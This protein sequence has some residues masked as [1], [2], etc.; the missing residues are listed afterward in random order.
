MIFEELIDPLNSE[1]SVIAE[2][3]GNHQS[4]LKSAMQF[5]EEAIRY[6][7]DIIKFQVYKPDTI[8]LKSTFEDFRV[9][10]NSSWKE[11]RFLY[12]LYEKAYT[13][14]D[15]IETIASYLDSVQFPWFASP[16]DITAIEFLE[17]I[18][19]PAY[20][21]ASPEITD[22]GLIETLSTTGKPIILSTGLANK[23][24]LDLAVNTIKKRHCKF[25]ILKCTSAYPAPYSDLNLN[26][27]PKLIENYKCA[28]G[29]SDHT[30]GFDAAKTAVALGATIIEKHFKLD[31]DQTSIDAHFS[32][33]ISQLT[34]FKKEIKNIRSSLGKNNLALENSVKPGLNGRRSLY[35]VKNIKKGERFTEHNVKSIRPVHGL[36]PK[37]LKRV[38]N[39]TA[40]Q[41]INAGSRLEKKLI[42]DF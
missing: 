41:N 19:C 1:V 31:N 11:Y 8:T 3:S 38:L 17:K 39:K 26:A 34:Q 7:A 28:V 35:V 10:T 5:V 27:I 37:Y 6:E 36:H 18:G 20:K 14:W 15:W 4:S 32:A 13:P 24:D 30:I 2:M 25:A 12:D 42:S 22:I 9:E 16:F 23:I 40:K 33:N 29:F 21:V